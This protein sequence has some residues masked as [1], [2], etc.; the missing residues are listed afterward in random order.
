MTTDVTSIR[1]PH[2]DAA[3]IEHFIASGE[4]KSRS[5]FI[6]YAIKKTINEILLQEFHERLN[7]PLDKKGVARIQKE[8]KE[9]RKRLWDE[10]VQHIS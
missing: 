7:E 2:K 8:I 10:Y 3:V 5:E 4:F 9:I 6:R 1:L